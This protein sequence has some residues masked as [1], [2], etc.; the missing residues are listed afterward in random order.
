MSFQARFH[1]IQQKIM[2]KHVAQVSL[3]TWIFTILISV[4]VYGYNAFT[5]SADIQTARLLNHTLADVSILLIGLSFALSGI[6]YFWN[7]ADTLI[8]YRKD[9]G[10]NGFYLA[11]THTIM[12]LI[13]RPV[14]SFLE[15][16]RI[17]PFMAAVLSLI[18]FTVM[19][20]VSNRYAITA[21]GGVGWRRILRF[22]YVGYVFGLIHLGMLN[23]DR[24]IA[25][26]LTTPATMSEVFAPMSFMV[27]TFGCMVLGLRIVLQMD[28]RKKEAKK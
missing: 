26:V 11:L 19:A 8:I 25:W 5:Q 20:S 15:P 1:R 16:E 4:V 22:G 9:L 14:T 23:V 18:I 3:R 24:W 12:V 6:C 10:L 27:F 13:R 2:P 7:F 28:L 21:L 17:G